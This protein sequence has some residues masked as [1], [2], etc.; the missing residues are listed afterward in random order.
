LVREQGREAAEA[1][2]VYVWRDLSFDA[3]DARDDSSLL[4]L[5]S[6]TPPAWN[7]TVR[8]DE[9][10]G[11]AAAFDAYVSAQQSPAG[12]QVESRTPTKAADRPAFLITRS[13]QVEGALLRQWQA[14]VLLGESVAVFT[15][16]ARPAAHAS[17]KAALDRALESL[18]LEKR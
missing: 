15:M 11:G 10:K 9:L 13:M 16:S 6:A 5:D 8:R 18:S 1:S 4:F 14:F 3:P 12:A 2:V 17:A 7:L